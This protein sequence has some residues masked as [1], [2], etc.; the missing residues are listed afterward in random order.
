MFYVVKSLKISMIVLFLV[1]D[2]VAAAFTIRH[3][4]KRP[5]AQEI[6]LIVR[7]TSPS[8]ITPA[9]TSTGSTP[10][11]LVITGG[12][13]ARYVSG[14]C[15]APEIAGLAISTDKAATFKEITLPLEAKTGADGRRSAL[16]T[17]IL[18]VTVT[19]ADEFSLIGT[20]AD[21]NAQRYTTKNGG[22]DWAHADAIDDWYVDN[23]NVVTPAGPSDAECEVS[24]VWAI[25]D[26][27]AR[28]ACKDGQIRGT[29]DGGSAWVGMGS[30][31]GME[32]ASFSTIRDGFAIAKD[33]DCDSRAFSTKAAGGQWQ[34][35]GCIQADKTGAA[36]SG[37]ADLLGAIVDGAVYVSTDQGTTWKQP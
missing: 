31:N 21:C 22:Q 17:S 14:S 24:S 27:N 6:S 16:V 8:A 26:R 34:P 28:V 37:S 11:G 29:D 23:L 4:N 30:L 3:V 1:V 9:T 25:S 33:T 32:A 35:L 12:I 18:G 36:I 7:S 10:D 15:D 20:D 5:V 19:A 13:M 2:L